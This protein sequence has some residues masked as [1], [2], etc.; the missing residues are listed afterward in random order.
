M[1]IITLISIVIF[2]LLL[3]EAVHTISLFFEH[4]FYWFARRV[5]N[6]VE[7]FD[8]SSWVSLTPPELDSPSELR[9]GAEDEQKEEENYLDRITTGWYRNGYYWSEKRKEELSHIFLSHR[10]LFEKLLSEPINSPRSVDESLNELSFTHEFMVRTA[11]YDFE[12]DSS[13][14][15]SSVY[16]AITSFLSKNN[17]SRAF[18]LQ[19]RYAFCR[20]M[21][22]VL[23]FISLFYFLRLAYPP[24]LTPEPLKYES[25]LTASIPNGQIVMVSF[26]L[27]GLAMTFA[28]AAGKYKRNYIEYLISEFYV[29]V[30]FG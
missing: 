6:T 28:W 13:S 30:H 21:W 20:G 1:F 15:L 8:L 29:S 19:A 18:R 11:I 16:P 26:L 12:V 27:I 3:G 9:D 2:G 10:H 17:S 4:M 24:N 23:S 14:D 22:T 25:Y 5:R 7:L